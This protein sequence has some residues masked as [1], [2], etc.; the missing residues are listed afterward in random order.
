MWW[1]HCVPIQCTILFPAY[2]SLDHS[3]WQLSRSLNCS[4]APDVISSP[5]QIF[6]IV[7]GTSQLCSQTCSFS[8]SS[9]SRI[10]N[11]FMDTGWITLCSHDFIPRFCLSPAFGPS[12]LFPIMNQKGLKGKKPPQFVLSFSFLLCHHFQCKWLAYARKQCEWQ[13]IWQGFLVA[14]V[15]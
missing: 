4:N 8:F 13:R 5:Q 11:S 15:C 3:V 7:S 9:G 6:N 12:S 2:T 10:K 14:H 1:S